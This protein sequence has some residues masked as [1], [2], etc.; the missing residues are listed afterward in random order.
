M[1][2][3]NLQCLILLLTTVIENVSLLNL[4]TL[5]K[6]NFHAYSYTTYKTSNCRLGI[7]ILV[8]S[9]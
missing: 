1:N 9:R 2:I 7:L 8:H 5:H 4:L 6:I 3:I